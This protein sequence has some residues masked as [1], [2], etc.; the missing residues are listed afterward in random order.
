MYMV[1]FDDFLHWKKKMVQHFPPKTWISFE[2]EITQNKL[3]CDRL[4]IISII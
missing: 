1:I 4:N 2:K 3:H